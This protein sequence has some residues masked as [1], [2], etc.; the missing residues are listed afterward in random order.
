MISNPGFV[1]PLFDESY[2]LKGMP[3]PKAQEKYNQVDYLVTEPGG[4]PAIPSAYLAG[5]LLTD[6][7][8]TAEYQELAPTEDPNPAQTEI[9]VDK[10]G[11]NANFSYDVELLQE[12]QQDQVTTANVYTDSHTSSGVGYTGHCQPSSDDYYTPP[13]AISPY[14]PYH[15]PAPHMA[16]NADFY[17]HH[18]TTTDNYPALPL[19][20]FFGPRVQPEYSEAFPYPQVPN[21]PFESMP[22]PSP[23]V[24]LHNFFEG[25]GFCIRVPEQVQ[26]PQ[27]QHF[28]HQSYNRVYQYALAGY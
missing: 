19:Q 22:L 1:P 11:L 21:P 25:T 28:Y 4:A 13:G 12:H 3:K 9:Q 7:V 16:T 10:L 6:E 20:P 8:P 14:H 23:D 15:V 27:F 18:P 26:Q 5:T 2:Y 24:P 17:S